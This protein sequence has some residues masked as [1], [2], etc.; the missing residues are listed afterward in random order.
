M[1]TEMPEHPPHNIGGLRH[2]REV[3]WVWGLLPH[4]EPNCLT[5]TELCM[6]IH[7]HLY[8]Y[9]YIHTYIQFH[10]FLECWHLRPNWP[11]YCFFA[12]Y[13]LNEYQSHF[14]G[15]ADSRNI[16]TPTQHV[17]SSMAPWRSARHDHKDGGVAMTQRWQKGP[18]LATPTRPEL[19]DLPARPELRRVL[20]GQ[21]CVIQKHQLKQPWCD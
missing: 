4:C 16:D 6:Y 13:L 8:M 11:T 2:S 12:D 18:L 1:Y 9:I 10:Q 5:G 14:F 20:P 19:E 15:G 3:R 17:G 7:I 21:T